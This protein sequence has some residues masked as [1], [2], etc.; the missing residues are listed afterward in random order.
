VKPW[1]P[2]DLE[3][4][5]A[6]QIALELFDE[7]FDRWWKLERTAP[8]RFSWRDER[9]GLAWPVS[10]GYLIGLHEVSSQEEA[11]AFA[12]RNKI[13]VH[14]DGAVHFRASAELVIVC[15]RPSPPPLDDHL[16]SIQ[17]V[18]GVTANVGYATLA[19][20]RLVALPAAEN[21]S[22]LPEAGT[23]STLVINGIDRAG[24]AEAAELS[25]YHLRNSF[26]ETGFRFW[27][28]AE[29]H[30]AP[31]FEEFAGVAAKPV[32]D[33]HIAKR[34]QVIAFYNR[35]TESDA[36]IAFLYYYRVL[37]ACFE[38]VLRQ[39]IEQWRKDTTVDELELMKRIRALNQK[40]DV[41][42]LRKIL[43]RIVNQHLLDKAHQS[44]LI[45]SPDADSLTNAIYGRRN[46]I[47]HGRKGQHI[48]VL[49]PF[50]FG[51]ERK[52]LAWRDIMAELAKATLARW[53]LTT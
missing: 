11:L 41:T 19:Y 23:I 37:E 3:P 17:M 27:P 24:I 32:T 34:P 53:V 6:E 47:A 18:D 36:V 16:F 50:A 25:L 45:S 1:Y 49:V 7:H 46:S 20:R 12:E 22:R 21:N 52:H 30:R 44:G 28:L 29:L 43:G 9:R 39:E 26:P 40:E 42:S 33:L 14:Q 51:D 38:D 2:N 8:Q 35:A 15:S 10:A 5:T 31:E 4:L 48:E 13:W